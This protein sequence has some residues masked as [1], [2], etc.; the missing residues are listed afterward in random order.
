MADQCVVIGKVR[1]VHVT[2]SVLVAA[3]EDVAKKF[4]ATAQK[5]PSSGAHATDDHKALDDMATFV[6]AGVNDTLG[7]VKAL[8]TAPVEKL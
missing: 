4:P 2:P 1:A 5:M 6:K 8:D 3:E 7:R